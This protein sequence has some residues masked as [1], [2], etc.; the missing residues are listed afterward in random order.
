MQI[1]QTYYK[2]KDM[3]RMISPMP[4]SVQLVRSNYSH[5]KFHSISWR[6]HSL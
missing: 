2:P 3:V 5:G 6:G 1:K 4:I